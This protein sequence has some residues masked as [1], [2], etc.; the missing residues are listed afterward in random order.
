[1]MI[2]TSNILDILCAHDFQPE[3]GL[4]GLDFPTTEESD[5]P[6]VGEMEEGETVYATLIAEVFREDDDGNLASSILKIRASASDG[7][8]LRTSSTIRRE[9]F[10]GEPLGGF[11][12]RIGSGRKSLPCA[13]SIPSSWRACGD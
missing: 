4:E 12:D 9:A 3:G 1:M 11:S 5:F 13:C 10:R 6:E 7:A 2:S 8:R